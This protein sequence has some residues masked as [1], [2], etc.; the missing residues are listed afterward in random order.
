MAGNDVPSPATFLLTRNAALDLRRIHARSVREWGEDAADDVGADDDGAEEDVAIAVPDVSG[1]TSPAASGVVEATAA[2][3]FEGF[4]GE[5]DSGWSIPAPGMPARP[6]DPDGPSAPVLSLIVDD[7]V[8]APDEAS[9]R[10]Q[11]HLQKHLQPKQQPM[12]R[13]LPK[14][15]PLRQKRPADLAVMALY[16]LKTK[17]A[18]KSL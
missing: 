9:E 18:N 11:K 5:D 17:S 2:P 16:W 12:K 10:L 15:S 14:L 6:A 3:V 4:G 13:L 8:A 1:W 7:P